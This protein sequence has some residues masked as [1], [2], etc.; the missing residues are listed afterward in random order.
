MGCAVAGMHYTA[1]RASL[2][3][4]MPNILKLQM[5]LAP[6]TLAVVI[7]IITVLVASI[8]LVGSFAGRQAELALTLRAEIAERERSEAEL[9]KARHE[10]EE[11]NRA[12]SDFLATMSHEIRTPL[13]GVIGMANLLASTPLNTGSWCG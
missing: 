2:F 13:N 6:M 9:I 4:P 11:A 3:Y 8:T 10:A 7:T 5:A 12:K 1:M